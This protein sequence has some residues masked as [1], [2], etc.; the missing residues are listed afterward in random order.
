VHLCV[1]DTRFGICATATTGLLR[2][3]NDWCARDDKNNNKL[4]TRTS[5]PSKEG[6][7]AIM[8]MR[9]AVMSQLNKVDSSE[10]DTIGRS[11][12][13]VASSSSAWFF[14]KQFCKKIVRARI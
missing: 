14:V 10:T 7:D 1:M 9:D 5:N 2:G 6:W 12:R 11:S 4:L 13:R 3:P 8:V